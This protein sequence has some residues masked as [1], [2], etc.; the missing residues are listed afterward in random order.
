MSTETAVKRGTKIDPADVDRIDRAKLGILLARPPQTDV[1][2][3]A[4]Y[5]GYTQCPWCGHVGWAVGLNTESYI[6]VVCGACGGYF[7][8]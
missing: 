4:W 5:S 8:A 2:G 6:D 7:R 3:Q 1:E